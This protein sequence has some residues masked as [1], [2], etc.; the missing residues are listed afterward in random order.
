MSVSMNQQSCKNCER[1]GIFENHR[2]KV[3]CS[4][5]AQQN[6]WMWDNQ[7]CYGV[8]GISANEN[9]EATIEEVIFIAFYLIR[10]RFIENPSNLNG[11]TPDQY[12]INNEIP[13]EGKTLYNDFLQ[14]MQYQ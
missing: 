5:C 9:R 2:L 10:P 7:R 3:P 8:N 13:D 11:L 1:Y 4:D 12:I 14:N 6:E